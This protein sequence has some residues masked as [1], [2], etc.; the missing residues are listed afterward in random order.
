MKF[1]NLNCRI[2]NLT[3]KVK[4]KFKILTILKKIIIVWRISQ[5]IKTLLATNLLAKI[6]TLK[7]NLSIKRICNKILSKERIK[8]I[9]VKSN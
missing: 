7:T 9:V 1:N 5:W 4:A 3:K 8:I 6:K 2:P